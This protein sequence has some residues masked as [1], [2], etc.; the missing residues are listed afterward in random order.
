LFWQEFES[1]ASLPYIEETELHPKLT[2]FVP[3]KN[4]IIDIEV[5]KTFNML[6]YKF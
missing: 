1:Y 2:H 4:T 6:L 5:Y 3:I